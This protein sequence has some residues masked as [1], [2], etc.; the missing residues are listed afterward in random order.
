MHLI[1]VDRVELAKPPSL[2]LCP[3]IKV[4][5]RLARIGVGFALSS[6][7]EV[8]VER[9]DQAARR[10]RTQVQFNEVVAEK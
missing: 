5:L 9:I 10:S 8:V 6:T 3:I 2:R 1:G 7:I 4:G